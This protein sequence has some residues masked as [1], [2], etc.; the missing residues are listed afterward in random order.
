MEGGG[1]S[2]RFIK[3]VLFYDWHLWGSVLCSLYTYIEWN[4]NSYDRFRMP[5]LNITHNLTPVGRIMWCGCGQTVDNLFPIP[6]SNVRSS[7]QLRVVFQRVALNIAT[8][9][10]QFNS[11]SWDFSGFVFRTWSFKFT[12]P[13]RLLFA[14]L[15]QPS[16]YRY[17]YY[18]DS[19]SSE[20]ITTLIHRPF[21][22]RIETYPF[23]CCWYFA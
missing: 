23:S 2:R 19:L 14:T 1:S 17:Y 20:F 5:L 15:L 6:N 22:N 9:Y 13:P 12:L 7:A 18:Y 21:L 16:A 11:F 3:L 4:L 8:I 10:A